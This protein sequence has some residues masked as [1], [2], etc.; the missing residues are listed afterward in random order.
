MY[1]H[2]RNRNNLT[3]NYKVKPHC[4][5]YWIGFHWMFSSGQMQHVLTALVPFVLTSANGINLIYLFQRAHP[6]F[7][8]GTCEK[9]SSS[10]NNTFVSFRWTGCRTKQS[11]FPR[12]PKVCHTSLFWPGICTG[13]WRWHE[14]TTCE[15]NH[16]RPL[17]SQW[18]QCFYCWSVG[19]SL[20][21]LTLIP[22]AQ[23]E[24]WRIDDIFYSNPKPRL[25]LLP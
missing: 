5:V 14:T 12:L 3:K 11:R 17:T 18:A 21:P 24:R 20:P 25:I 19:V 1:M 8:Y 22:Y 2:T 13:T 15:T 9:S 6:S 16:R 23:W 7:M 4:L 10:N